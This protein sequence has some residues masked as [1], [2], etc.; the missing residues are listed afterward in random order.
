MRTLQGFGMALLAGMMFT[1]P[2]G[3]AQN[4][5]NAHAGSILINTNGSRLGIGGADLTPEKAKAL[6]LKEERGA[7]VTM[8]GDNTPAS[9][10]GLKPGDVILEFNHVAIEDDG[11]LVYVVSTSEIG[12]KVPV[13]VYRNRETFSVQIELVGKE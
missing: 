4:A 3:F 5:S 1:A 10:A 2:G 13:L 9:K 6:K 8:V 11:H 7:E 12:A